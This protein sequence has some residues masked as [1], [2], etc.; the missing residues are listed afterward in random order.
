MDKWEIWCGK[1]Y[2]PHAVRLDVSSKVWP[3]F[4][5]KTYK[6]ARE[7]NLHSLVVGE[8]QPAPILPVCFNRTYE[9]ERLW[10]IY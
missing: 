2:F 1:S 8:F 7:D 10:V 5:G 4:Q 3:C 6:K 9:S